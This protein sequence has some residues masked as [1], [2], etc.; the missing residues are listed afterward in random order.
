MRS[1]SAICL[2]MPVGAVAGEPGDPGGRPGLVPGIGVLTWF[3]PPAVVEEAIDRAGCREQR[4][5]LLPAAVTIYFVLGMCLLSCEGVLAPPGYRA[6]MRTLSHGVRHLAGLEVPSAAALCKARLR[7]GVKALAILFDLLR[8]PLSGPGDPAAHAFGRLLAAW[9]ATEAGVRG[10]ALNAASFGLAG[11]RKEQG[12]AGSP[13]YRVLAV[14]EC[15]T[16]AVIDAVFG[17]FTAVSELVLARQALACL[18]PGMLLLADR[19]FPGWD[20]WGHAA[21][22]G[23]DLCWRVGATRILPVLETLPDGSWIS[24]MPSPDQGGK[25]GRTLARGKIP[26]G[27][28]VRVIAYAVTVT[29]LKDGSTRAEHCRLLTT[30]LDWR[31]APARDLAAIYHERWEAEG[32][33]LEFKVRLKGS[34][35]VLRSGSPGL[36]D[37]ELLAFLCVSQA[38]AALRCLAARQAPAAVAP[39]RASFTVTLAVA[40]DHLRT[41][42]GLLAPGGP[43]R[44]LDCAARDIRDALNPRRRDRQCP[45]E[46]KSR[47]VRFPRGSD[48]HR[49]PAAITIG[50][51]VQQPIAQVKNRKLTALGYPPGLPGTGSAQPRGATPV[52]AGNR[53]SL[54]GNCPVSPTR[55]LC[56]WLRE[57]TGRRADGTGQRRRHFRGRG[58]PDG[59]RRRHWHER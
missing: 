57:G 15:G 47:R 3:I 23:A 13:Q 35:L 22:T 59:R 6:V 4:A 51:T 7:V 42:A 53:P 14:V 26:S 36:A 43:A 25:T 24:V 12:P 17:A 39:A 19:N 8:G 34:G 52:S 44:A 28:R 41:Q 54:P 50:I 5:R 38:L 40:R 58:T 48:L 1:Q 16:H 45:R 10:S 2:D 31:Q 9:D 32:F 20:L 37:Q 30:I 27:H 55:G 46:Q 18:R 49:P 29:S 33:F 21:A 11:G 56:G